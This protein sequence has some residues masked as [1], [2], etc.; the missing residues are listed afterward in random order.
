MKNH[1]N[2]ILLLWYIMASTEGDQAVFDMS[3]AS[4]TKTNSP[5]LN[6]QWVSLPDTSNGSY[7]SNQ[8]IFQT[9]SIANSQSWA[10]YKNAF[11]AMPLVYSLTGAAVTAGATALD[12]AIVPKNSYLHM[13]HNC[14]VQLGSTAVCSQVNFA[15]IWNSFKLMT[16]LNMNDVLSYGATIGFYPDTALSIGFTNTDNIGTLNNRNAASSTAAVAALSVGEPMN[17]GMLK[18]AQYINYNPAATPVGGGSAY[19]TLLTANACNNLYKSYVYTSSASVKQICVMAIIRLRDLHSFFNEIPLNKKTQLTITL[20]L[21]QTICNMTV[22]GD[23]LTLNS[24]N[25]PIGGTCPFMIAAATAGNGADALTA[26]GL[27]ASCYVGNQVQSSAQVAAGA[28]ASPLTNQCVL[29]VPTYTFDPTVEQAYLSSSVKRMMY[30][31]IQSYQVPTVAPNAG[32]RQLISSGIAGLKSVLTVPYFAPG[33]NATGNRLN[34]TCLLSPFDSAGSTT[35]PFALLN[36][37]N[38][39]VSGTNV[40]IDNLSYT[41]QTFLQQFYGCNSYNAGSQYGLGGDGLIGQQ[42]FETAYAFHYVNVSRMPAF[43]VSTPKSVSIL[44]TNQSSRALDL[45]VFCEFGMVIE[46][47]VFTGI[48]KA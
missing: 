16:S 39:Q 41:Y 9:V 32:F 29:W 38:V 37:Y 23:V 40:L 46:L 36:N 26:G 22:T 8:A 43:E 44:G 5:F 45:T 1:K 33:L 21:N 2:I 20:G 25:N 3:M 24:T 48:R 12:Y 30:T 35:S 10:D 15:N 28:Q 31:D 14:Q 11:I 13:I 18:R 6:K 42:E 17:M 4:G 34:T 7:R 19:S 27:D 47:D